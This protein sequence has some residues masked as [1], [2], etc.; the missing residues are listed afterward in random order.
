MSEEAGRRRIR[1]AGA[2]ARAAARPGRVGQPNVLSNAATPN[3]L[4]TMDSRP[5]AAR[6]AT[7]R[8]PATRQRAQ[9]TAPGEAGGWLTTG[10]TATRQRV[11]LP[12][13]GTLVFLVLVAF[14][15]FRLVGEF[16]RGLEQAPPNTGPAGPNQ[17]V[18]PG[19]IIFGTASDG[20]CGVV[21]TAHDFAAGT[22]VWWSARLA[23]EQRPDAEVVVIVRRDGS[24][25][26]R[27]A[28]PPDESFGRWS[29]ACSTS[30]MAQTQPGLYLVE[31]WDV[32]VTTR[33]AIGEYRLTPA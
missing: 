18:V 26:D 4:S 11:G 17:A 8:Q 32:S 22:D 30:P 29:F 23:T 28:V 24:E 6:Q 19:S 7:A 10:R 15:G 16:V 9:P 3:V 33:H 14:T 25:V 5:A 31:I 21:G 2:R 12:S 27:W 20:E 1:G 13:F